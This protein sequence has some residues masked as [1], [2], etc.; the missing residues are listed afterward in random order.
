M[1]S[2]SPPTGLRRS[3]FRLA[4]ED[5]V[6]LSY[7]AQP[8]SEL[9]NLSRSESEVARAAMAG[10]SNAEIAAHRGCSV[11]TVQNQLASVYRKLG[12]CSRAELTVL[13]ARQRTNDAGAHRS[14]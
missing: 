8:E 3:V 6:V 12:V 11:F 14:R 10:L 1:D 5:F 7:P 4:G 13:L 9:M 2:E